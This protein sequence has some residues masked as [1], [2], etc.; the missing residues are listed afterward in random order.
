MTNADFIRLFA[1]T[2]ASHPEMAEETR[3]H[4]N[5]EVF[6]RVADLALNAPGT[7]QAVFDALEIVVEEI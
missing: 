6:A 5:R 3:E 1:I 4:V 2:A 7:A